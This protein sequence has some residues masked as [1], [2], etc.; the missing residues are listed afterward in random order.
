MA[1]QK[2]VRMYFFFGTNAGEIETVSEKRNYK[3]LPTY[4]PQL[5][6][7]W[8]NLLIHYLSNLQ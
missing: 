4:L 8:Y 7:G 3:V 6:R 2:K 5:Q 1:T